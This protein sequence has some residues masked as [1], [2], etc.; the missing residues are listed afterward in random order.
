MQSPRLTSSRPIFSRISL[1]AFSSHCA[2]LPPLSARRHGY[3]V[4]IG[5]LAI[6][7]NRGK[8]ITM[9]IT[10]EGIYRLPFPS[11]KKKDVR[12]YGYYIEQ[13][14]TRSGYCARANLPRPFGI[15]R[16]GWKYRSMRKEVKIMNVPATTAGGYQRARSLACSF[17]RSFVPRG[18]SFLRYAN[19]R[20][21][22]E[23]RDDLAE[24]SRVTASA[25][26]DTC[27]QYVFRRFALGEFFH[28]LY[29]CCSLVCL[30]LSPTL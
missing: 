10:T 23:R 29:T 8:S 7:A 1:S 26:S 4:I 16:K 2:L 12:H 21:A 5:R 30:I 25:I 27:N 3:D 22:I 17:V 19:T 6:T 24:C 9:D 13:I 28:G 14:R 18:R 15:N 20:F 11:E